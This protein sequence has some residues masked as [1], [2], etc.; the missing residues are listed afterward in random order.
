MD[1]KQIYSERLS[2][3]EQAV[4][5]IRSGDRVSIGHAAG[6]P[7]HIVQAM[8]ANREAYR[9]VEI[10]HMI[11]MGQCE[12]AQPGM[13]SHFRHISQFAGTATCGTIMAGHGD[14]VPCH[15]SC[16][17]DQLDTTLPP[18]VS[19]ICVSPPDQHGWC[20]FGV[21][22]DY[23]KRSAEVAELVIAQVNSQMPRTLGDS[24]IHVSDLDVIVEH[25]APLM[26]L[27]PPRITEVE[28]RIG[29]HCASLVRDGDCLHLGIGAVPEAVPVFLREKRH[30]GIHTEMLTDSIADLYEAGAVTSKRK[31]LHKG[32]MVAAFMMGSQRLYDFAHD[33]PC[34]EMHPASYVSDP[35]VAAQNDCL[36]S[37]SACLQMDLSGQVCTEIEGGAQV[38]GAGGQLDFI[39]AAAMSRCGRSIIALPSAT[40]GE[41][42]S[43][44]VPVLDA[45]ACVS[46]SRNEV[47][48]VIT[49][50]GIANLKYRTVRDRA[51]RLI[52]IA[53]PKFRPELI[54][55][56]ERQ[57]KENYEENATCLKKSCSS[58]LSVRP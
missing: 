47:E 17:P 38:A 54:D 45:G 42:A 41:K 3:V 24:F 25:D 7:S 2:T 11:P 12:Y 36:V 57:F 27:P 29:E 20:S 10:T 30:L 40:K 32:K 18:D 34:V 23:T 22:V 56:F 31:T 43:R 28:R 33:N 53:H 9:N 21:S 8:V 6:E 26:T 35:V 48:Y 51:R 37:I 55:A 16:I 1:W 15:L 44:I 58:A 46:V 19:I 52:D 4:T 49:E 5:Y 14:Y 50:Y 13:E 39:R